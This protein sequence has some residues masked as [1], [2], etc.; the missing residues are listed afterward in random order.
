MC[1]TWPKPPSEPLHKEKPS[2]EAGLMATWVNCSKLHE[3]LGS[4]PRMDLRK[5]SVLCYG[6]IRAGMQSRQI[7]PGFLVSRTSIMASFRLVR[8]PVS[9]FKVR[10]I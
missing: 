8:A 6:N 9:K 3:H 2:R 10:S 1:P 7:P 5:V 4:M